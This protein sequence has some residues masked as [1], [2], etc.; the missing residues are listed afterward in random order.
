MDNNTVLRSLRYAMDIKDQEMNDIFTL[1]GASF[2]TSEVS[3]MLKAEDHED[4]TELPDEG[5]LQ[6]LDGL[7]LKKRGPSERPAAKVEE[8]ISN[9]LMMRKIRI[10]FELKED[11]MIRTIGKGGFV[12][13]KAELTA[14]FRKKGHKHYRACGDQMMR[15]FLKGLGSR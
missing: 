10:A 15:Y 1:G 12:V 6:F 14:L 11:D 8:E 4:F 2:E 13:K 9:N 7:I 3:A 5:M